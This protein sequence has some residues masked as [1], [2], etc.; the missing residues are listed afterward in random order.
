LTRDGAAVPMREWA[1]AI[2]DRV[3]AAAQALDAA[4]GDDVHMRALRAQ[5]IKLD[6]PAQTP[7]ARVLAIMR[8]HGQTFLAFGLAQSEAH[9]AYF[10][11]RPLDEAAAAEARARSAR[12]LAEQAEL[13]SKNAGSFDAF[14]AA[15]RAYTLN[16]FSV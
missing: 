5:R 13:E 6:D 14:V 3:E 9:A 11:A 4:R 8:E 15:Y 16:R 1:E 7:A 2:F 10:R 12:S